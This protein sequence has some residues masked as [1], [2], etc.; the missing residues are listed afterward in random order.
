M[1]S[2]AHA[3]S[4]YSELVEDFEPAPVAAIG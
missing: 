4:H 2:Q 3:Y 1:F